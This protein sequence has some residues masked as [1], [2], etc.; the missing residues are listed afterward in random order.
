MCPWAALSSARNAMN[1]AYL[2]RRC[3]CAHRQLRHHVEQKMRGSPRCPDGHEPWR[4]AVEV[5]TIEVQQHVRDQ[6]RIVLGD[7]ASP[8][9]HDLVTGLEFLEMTATAKHNFFA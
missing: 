3:R 5:E 4:I 9:V 7:G 6:H 8:R 2:T 1:A